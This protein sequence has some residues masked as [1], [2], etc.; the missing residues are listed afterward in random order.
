M[1]QIPETTPGGSAL[2]FYASLR[3]KC[4]SRKPCSD[5]PNATIMRM[6]IQKTKLGGDFAEVIEVPFIF[7]QGFARALDIEAVA[8]E[9]GILRHSAGQTKVQWVPDAEFEPLL[10]DIEKGKAAGQQA[11]I[12][13][14]LLLE[15]LRQA[16]FLHAN[17]DCALTAEQVLAIGAPAESTEELEESN[18]STPDID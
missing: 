18:D 10:P 7:G 6:K 15:K 3:I 14:P 9:L 1:D 8:K 16:C 13:M 2:R 17:A 11:L 5:I 4:M 12:D